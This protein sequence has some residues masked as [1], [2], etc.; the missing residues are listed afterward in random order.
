M[1]GA[2]GIGDGRGHSK[3]GMRNGAA[4][5]TVRSRANSRRLKPSGAIMPPRWSAYSTVA[6]EPIFRIQILSSPGQDAAEESFH[7]LHTDVCPHH[8]VGTPPDLPLSYS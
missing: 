1:G 8:D 4:P 2:G 7:G 3:A 5:P 6:S